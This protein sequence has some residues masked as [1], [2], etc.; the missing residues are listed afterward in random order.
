M[1]AKD[2]AVKNTPTMVLKP[3]VPTAPCL[4]S[5]LSMGKKATDTGQN[6]IESFKVETAPNLW[7]S[8]VN[9]IM[10]TTLLSDRAAM[11]API[12]ASES[13]SPPEDTGVKANS[14]YL[15][16]SVISIH[17]RKNKEKHHKHREKDL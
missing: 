1:P 4:A 16:N 9:S 3:N 11:C 10:T 14:G 6:T 2:Q 7:C 5:T 12:C 15:D 13:P 8:G 17:E